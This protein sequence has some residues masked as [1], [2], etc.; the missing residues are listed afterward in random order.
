MVYVDKP[1]ATLCAF[2]DDDVFGANGWA[3]AWS[4]HRAVEDL[5]PVLEYQTESSQLHTAALSSCWFCA[6]QISQIKQQWQ[7]PLPSNFRVN[8]YYHCPPDVQPQKITYFSTYI[9]DAADER[10]TGNL[11]T[12]P[13]GATARTQDL[14]SSFFLASAESP[15]DW[16]NF[17][18]ATA[19][20]WITNCM[21]QHPE[22]ARGQGSRLPFRILDVAS[23]A[24]EKTIILVQ[25]SDGIEAD[26]A[27]LSYCW[28]ASGNLTTNSLKERKH[29][30]GIPIVSL[31]NT[32]QDTVLVTRALGL[33]YL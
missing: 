28:G 15:G 13:V 9:R 12:F 22:C 27:A 7:G 8:L 10:L 30:A 14:A 11:V 18:E 19:N 5:H 2:C 26:Y 33:R 4:A 20:E 29:V 25:N 16:T 23:R 21:Q 6:L 32:I 31:P 3:K 24:I 1:K 17:S